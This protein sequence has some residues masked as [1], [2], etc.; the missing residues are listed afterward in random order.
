[1]KLFIDKQITEGIPNGLVLQ[2][3]GYFSIF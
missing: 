2:V 1:M 3:Y